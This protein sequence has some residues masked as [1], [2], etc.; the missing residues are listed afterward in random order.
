MWK[1][2]KMICLLI[3][4]VL[5]VKD[6]RTRTVSLNLLLAAGIC[7]VIYQIAYGKENMPLVAG[8]MAV[9]ALFLLVSKI[10]EEGLGYGD[11]FGIFI[12]GTYLGFFDLVSVLM[13][14]FFLLL[15]VSIPMLIRR[16]MSKK[17]ALPFYPFLTGGYLCLLLAEGIK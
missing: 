14:A 11:S 17:A 10:T 2:S 6:I 15:C 7:S 4:L 8:G 13:T 1:I 5:S 12:L 9:G 3:L 16:K